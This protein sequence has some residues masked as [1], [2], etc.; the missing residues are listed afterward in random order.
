[1]GSKARISKHILP[2]ILENLKPDQY[3]V[4]LFCGGCNFTDKVNHPYVIANDINSSLIALWQALQKGWIPPKWISKD[5]YYDIKDNQYVFEP[6]LVGW[7]CFCCSYS[8]KPFSGFAGEH[9]PDT[10]VLR[11]YQT[12]TY[13]YVLKQIEKLQSVVFTNLPYDEVV[14]PEGSIIYADP[15][16][17]GTTGY[18]VKFDHERFYSWARIQQNLF[19]SEYWMPEDFIEIWSGI[20]RSSLSANGLYGGS[21]KTVEKLFIHESQFD[22]YM[23]NIL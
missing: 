17:K 10:G 19:I 23:K 13:N 11:N 8:G 18:R 6:E 2:I 5:E 7:A 9:I 21:K 16:Y 15:P 22:N 1:M 14:I 4:E 20:L 3:F 12:E